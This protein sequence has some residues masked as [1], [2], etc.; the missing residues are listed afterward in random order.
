MEDLDGAMADYDRALQLKPD[1]DR[2]YNNRGEIKRVRGDLDGAIQDYDK[3]IQLRKDFAA[4][5]NN[6]CE[7][8]FQKGDM[9]GALED[10]DKAVKLDPRLGPESDGTGEPTMLDMIRKA[11]KKTG[12]TI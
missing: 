6:R 11:V 8:K 5:Y 12:K 7:A 2:V 10:F 1:L 4:A 3:A 9:E